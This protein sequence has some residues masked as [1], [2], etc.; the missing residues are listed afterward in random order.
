VISEVSSRLE[1]DIFGILPESLILSE[2]DWLVVFLRN[3]CKMYCLFQ[4]ASACQGVRRTLAWP[5]FTWAWQNIRYPV[6]IYATGIVTKQRAM[7]T[8]PPRYHR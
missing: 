5:H 4:V 6:R 7:L 2:A 3:V 8:K 1:L